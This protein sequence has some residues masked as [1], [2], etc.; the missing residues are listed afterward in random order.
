MAKSDMDL[1]IG[2]AVGMRKI[3][4]TAQEECLYKK[5]MHSRNETDGIHGADQLTYHRLVSN[6]ISGGSRPDTF[7][8]S[9]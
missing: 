8:Q 6:V 1:T 3:C 2:F 5:V 4:E 9:T 7:D